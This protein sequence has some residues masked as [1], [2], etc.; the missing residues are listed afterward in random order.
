MIRV[1][2]ILKTFGPRVVTV[3]ME[4]AHVRRTITI[5]VAPLVSI[6]V[7]TISFVLEDTRTPATV[8]SESTVENTKTHN[9]RATKV[10]QAL[11]GPSDRMVLPPSNSFRPSRAS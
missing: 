11:F 8:L 1:S 2:W 7:E 9:S 10:I 3:G 5:T 6:I 4:T